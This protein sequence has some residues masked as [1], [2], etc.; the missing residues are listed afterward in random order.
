[1]LITTD[2]WEDVTSEL[3]LLTGSYDYRLIALSALLAMSMS[4]AGFELTER[5]LVSRGGTRVFWLVCGGTAMGIGLWAAL[6]VGMLAFSLP[7]PIFY[8]YPT[9][10][11]GLLAAIFSTTVGLFSATRER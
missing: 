6:Y 3:I 4:Y 9:L 2:A 1:M 11:L 7:V 5:M 8:H 10:G